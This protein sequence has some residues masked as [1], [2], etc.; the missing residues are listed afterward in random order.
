MAAKRPQRPQPPEKRTPPPAAT[1]REQQE[2][3]AYQ[4]GATL[5]ELHLQQG[6]VLTAVIEDFDSRTIH[7]TTTDGETIAIAR[8]DIRYLGVNGN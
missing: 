7:V 8:R 2:L 5:V 3:E 6:E 1:G 4:K